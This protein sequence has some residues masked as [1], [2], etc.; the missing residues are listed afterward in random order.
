MTK[1]QF[2]EMVSHPRF[3]DIM[4]NKNP[5]LKQMIDRDPKILEALKND[6]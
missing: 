6:R 5:M 3:I 1:E 4:M 2:I